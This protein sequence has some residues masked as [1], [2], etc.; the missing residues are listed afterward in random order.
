M[1]R[2]TLSCSL[3]AVGM[4]VVAAPAWA[5]ELDEEEIRAAIDRGVKY[6]KSEQ[7]PAGTWE[8]YPAYPGGVTGLCALALL[9]AGV[10]PDDPHI[11]KAL[12]ALRKLPPK[13]TYV[14]ALQTMV[15][16]VAAPK[17]DL[18]RIQKNVRWLEKTQIKDGPYEGTW[19]YPT[20]ARGDNSNAHFALLALHAASEAGVKVSDKTWRLALAYWRKAQNDD[21]SWGYVDNSRGTGSM[22]CAGIAG[23]AIALR[24]LARN[25]GA[26]VDQLS[27]SPEIARGTKW[28]AKHFTVAGNP[29]SDISSWTYYYLNGL[30]E[31]GHLTEQRRIGEHDWYREG[32]QQFVREQHELTGLWKGPGR[33]EG[34]PQIG[35]SLAL[36]F[37]ARGLP[38]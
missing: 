12:A 28:L 5:A 21:G 32:A 30:E 20:T 10:P 27:Q 16:C 31:V 29:G 8:E 3:A 34:R 1:L 14:T 2:K 26:E 22:T 11:Q 25:R 18:A 38:K 4:A 6:L 17:R 33:I 7:S 15:L 19:S 35:T 36:L 23:A 13:R 37:L 9:E 24:G